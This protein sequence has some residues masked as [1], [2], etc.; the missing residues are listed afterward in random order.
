MTEDM[1]SS[2]P[3]HSPRICGPGKAN[4]W[5]RYPPLRMAKVVLSR[6]RFG[7]ITVLTPFGRGRVSEKLRQIILYGNR[8]LVSGNPNSQPLNLLIE[9]CGVT[10][11]VKNQ[12]QRKCLGQTQPLSHESQDRIHEIIG[13]KSMNKIQETIESWLSITWNW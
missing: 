12:A 8:S 2:L 9:T 7:C 13:F 10:P 6:T 5:T 4:P 3:Y 11:F 1:A